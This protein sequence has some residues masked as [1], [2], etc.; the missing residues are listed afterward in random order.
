MFALSCN[1]SKEFNNCMHILNKHIDNYFR[2][3][4]IDQAENNLPNQIG[5]KYS[6]IVQN[7][8]KTGTTEVTTIALR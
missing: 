3:G 1:I 6:K 8:S 7:Q 4:S 5:C 2:I